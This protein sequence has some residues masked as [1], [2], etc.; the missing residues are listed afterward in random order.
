MHAVSARNASARAMASTKRPS[1]RELSALFG[2]GG[3]DAPA[4]GRAPVK[5]GVRAGARKPRLGARAFATTPSRGDG[6]KRGARA[7]ATTPARTPGGSPL[8]STPAS[9]GG[10]DVA[11]LRSRFAKAGV[12]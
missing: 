6:A 1:V 2:G 8:P 11:A 9:P 10:V 7:G 12:L 5:R 3:S 4:V